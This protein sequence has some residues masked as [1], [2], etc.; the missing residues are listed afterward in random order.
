MQVT[1]VKP[2][3]PKGFQPVTVQITFE[4]SEEL[5]AITTLLGNANGRDTPGSYCLWA[6]LRKI[7]EA[8]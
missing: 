3:V 8:N 7:V 1:Q 4:T 5:K 2:E 6:A